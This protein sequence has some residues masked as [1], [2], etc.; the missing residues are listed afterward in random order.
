MVPI[1]AKRFIWNIFIKNNRA[2][3]AKF[4]AIW[5]FVETL[6]NTEK[7]PPKCVI[8]KGVLEIF[9]KV[10]EKHLR[11]TLFFNKVVGG[12]L[13]LYYNKDS[14]TGIFL[15][16]IMFKVCLT[17]LRHYAFRATPF[18]A[19]G[20]FLYPLKSSENLWC[21][22]IS[23]KNVLPIKSDWK[24]HFHKSCSLKYISKKF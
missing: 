20:L 1:C 2:C 12:G 23:A 18:H 9:S 19:T 13:Q 3:S 11:H 15:L 5:P 16:K 4:H 10:T 14:G 17:I 8:Q 6:A 22:L 21:L 7:Q 24:W